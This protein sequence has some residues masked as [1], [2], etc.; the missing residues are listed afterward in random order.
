V[1]YGLIHVDNFF[2]EC[3]NVW[4]LM[5]GLPAKHYDILTRFLPNLCYS[6]FSQNQIIHAQSVINIKQI[7]SISIHFL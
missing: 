1:D 7:F 4:L 6:L 2:I 3:V 5:I